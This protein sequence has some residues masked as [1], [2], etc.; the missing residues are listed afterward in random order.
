MD[1]V[2][3]ADQLGGDVLPL[4]GRA[5]GT[6]IPVMDAGHGIE[7]VRQVGS[8]RVKDG[9]SLLVAGVGMGDGDGDLIGRGL[10][11]LQRAGQLR[12]HVRDPQQAL[13][14]VIQPDKGVVVRQSE[15]GNVLGALLLL[16]EER[17]LHLNTH[18]LCTALRLRFMEPHR[19]AEG[20]FQHVIG[21]RHRGG[22]EGGHAVLRQIGGH[23]HKTVI[24]AV[25]EVRAGVAV[26]VDIHQT[27]D[28]ICAV[29]VDALSV[30]RFRQHMG[31]PAVRHR[32]A[33]GDEPAVDKDISVDKPHITPPADWPP[34]WTGPRGGTARPAA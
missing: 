29:K 18:Q 5:D 1:M 13:R 31:E 26:G 11:E 17:P 14:R 33:A 27:G 7:Q 2:A 32:E 25:G 15:I 22:G 4:R 8:A 10:D 3:V 20:R 34:P 19:R 23:F 16:G 30:R 24:I 28:H 9:S 6:G 12:G 21:Q